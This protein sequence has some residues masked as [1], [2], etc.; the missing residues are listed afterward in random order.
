MKI[1]TS[2]FTPPDQAKESKARFGGDG[3]VAFD[4]PSLSSTPL[5]FTRESS[6]CETEET[7]AASSGSQYQLHADISGQIGGKLLGGSA[8]GQFDKNAAENAGVR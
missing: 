2:L 7:A 6:G 8:R 4:L 3:E 1:G 5:V